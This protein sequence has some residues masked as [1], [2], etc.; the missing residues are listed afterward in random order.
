MTTTNTDLDNALKLAFD[1]EGKEANKAYAVFLR[2]NFFMPVKKVEHEEQ[3]FVPLFIQEGEHFFIPVFD[4]LERLQH[5]SGDNEIEYTQL[6]GN[7]VIRGLG[8][9]VVLCL[10]IGSPYYK[11]FLPDEITRL[12]TMVAKLDQFKSMKK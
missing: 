12:K 9:N 2:T 6:M 11:E 10:N 5:W 4:T 3:P 7:A 8:E 1:T